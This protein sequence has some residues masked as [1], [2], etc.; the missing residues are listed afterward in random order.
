MSHGVTFGSDSSV[1]GFFATGVETG[2]FVELAALAL[3]L[4]PELIPPIF[5]HFALFGKMAK[6]PLGAAVKFR[7]LE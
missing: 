2:E 1:L 7:I 6:S 4:I 3:C 5:P